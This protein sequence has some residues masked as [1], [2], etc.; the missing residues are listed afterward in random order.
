MTKTA[1]CSEKPLNPQ[2]TVLFGV[3]L[4]KSSIKT[5]SHIGVVRH[6]TPDTFIPMN[7]SVTWRASEHQMPGL[8]EAKGLLV[9]AELGGGKSS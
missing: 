1:K 6:G 5:Q 9:L 7:L 4:H 3:N 2:R 8:R